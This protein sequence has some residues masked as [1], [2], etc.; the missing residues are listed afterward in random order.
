MKPACLI[1]SFHHAAIIRPGCARSRTAFPF[2]HN[3]VTALAGTRQP[4]HHRP[5]T[6]EQA[7]TAYIVFTRESTSDQAELD[8][9]SQTVA[10]TFEGHPL[11][12]LAAYGA[13]E[14]LEGTAPEGVV[15]LEFPTV[16][17]ARAWYDSPAY[18]T[19]VQHRWKGA[20][21][22]VVIVQGV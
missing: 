2:H 7:M 3:G 20:S 14:V 10:P 15:I 17:A 13:Q 5:S 19:V 1:D 9:Y 18:Q 11:K 22:R 8:A 6:G 16:E 21:Y 4:W 12:V